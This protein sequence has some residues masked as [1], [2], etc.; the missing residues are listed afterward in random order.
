MWKL[1]NMLSS[2]ALQTQEPVLSSPTPSS[3]PDDRKYAMLI[4][5]AEAA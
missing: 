5:L 4:C 1:I 2:D 3:S